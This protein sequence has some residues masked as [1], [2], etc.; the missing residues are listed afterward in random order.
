M[1]ESVLQQKADACRAAQAE[2][3]KAIKEYEH[4][5]YELQELN[6]QVDALRTKIVHVSAEL[7][8]CVLIKR[9]REDMVRLA[10]DGMQVVINSARPGWG[11]A[12]NDTEKAYNKY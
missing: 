8:R 11:C 4:Y 1:T 7:D 6:K 12:V 10:L 2:L 3:D 5:T 9:H